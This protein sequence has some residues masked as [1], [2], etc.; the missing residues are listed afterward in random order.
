MRIHEGSDLLGGGSLILGLRLA[1]CFRR[2]LVHGLNIQFR[3]LLLVVNLLKINVEIFVILLERF[4]PE[5]RPHSMERRLRRALWSINA[6]AA[7]LFRCARR[8]E[9]LR[10]GCRGFLVI[11]FLNIQLVR[12]LLTIFLLGL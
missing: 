8:M 12:L 5:S 11:V 10:V 7:V 2:L 4:C 3:K 9:T 6:R 1:L